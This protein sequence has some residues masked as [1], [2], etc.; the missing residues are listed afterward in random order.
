MLLAMMYLI[1]NGSSRGV[2]VNGPF[3]PGVVS[4]SLIKDPQN[5]HISTKLNGKV[6]QDS[7]T[8]D[9]VFGVAKTIAFLSQGTTLLPGDLIFTGT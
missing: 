9:M 1:G 8:K 3:G 7:T 5:L 6:V 4:A 2:E